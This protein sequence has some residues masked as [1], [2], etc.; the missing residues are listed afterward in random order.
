MGASS[1]HQPR[2]TP[3]PYGHRQLYGQQSSSN[4]RIS[5]MSATSQGGGN[6]ISE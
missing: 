2:Q 1:P 6:A 5:G 3:P 4:R